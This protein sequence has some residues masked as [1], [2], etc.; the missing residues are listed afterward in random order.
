M[1]VRKL[2][3]NEIT[4]IVCPITS[5]G[6]FHRVVARWNPPKG[7]SFVML[8]ILLFHKTMEPPFEG[9]HLA[10][11]FS[12]SHPSSI[13]IKGI[14]RKSY[15]S[16]K[17]ASLRFLSTAHNKFRN[18]N[19]KNQINFEMN[20]TGTN[21][22]YIQYMWSEKLSFCKWFPVSL[23]KFCCFMYQSIPKP[24]ISPTGNPRAFDS[25]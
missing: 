4:S 21:I 22:M 6:W 17:L 3:V 15:A 20:H 1:A 8:L 7:R 12:F 18:F 13:R 25:R 16:E 2:D 24:P 5:L 9:F 11:S 10:T 23:M 14:A 19:Q